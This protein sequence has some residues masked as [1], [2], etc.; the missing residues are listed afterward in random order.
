MEAMG[1]SLTAHSIQGEGTTFTLE[2]AVAEDPLEHHD[3][4]PPAHPAPR[5]DTGAN[6]DYTVLHVED[7]SSNLRLVERILRQRGGVQ[8]LTAARG[9][10]VQDLVRQHRPDLVLLDLHL[11]DIDGEEV[12]R[13]L[14]ADPHTAGLPVVVVSAD[15]TH[16]YR[17]RLLAA[18]A[19]A[20][21]TKPLDVPHVLETIDGLLTLVAMP[22]GLSRDSPSA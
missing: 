12:L 10:I 21:L 16:G 15:G 4:N 20:Y 1:G 13:R 14:Q 18:G 3:A 9:D 8:L 7:N 22:D 11:P 5:Q 2:L 19:A 6:R 17:E